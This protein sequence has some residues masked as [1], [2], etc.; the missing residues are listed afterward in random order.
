[1]FLKLLILFI[2]VPLLEIAILVKI[3]TFIGFWPTMLIVIVTGILGATLA[4]IEGFIVLNKIRN[5]LQLGKI[6]AEELID[7]FLILVGGIVLLTPGLLT[8]LLGFLILIPW[9]R[10]IFKKW[11]GKKSKEWVR[12]GTSKVTYHTNYNG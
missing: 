11:L 5:E 9:S 10:N 12:S 8:D 2:G 7:G 1:M 6:P 3:G 4:R